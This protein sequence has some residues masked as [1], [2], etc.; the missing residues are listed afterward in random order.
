MKS[1]HVHSANRGPA[2]DMY[3]DSDSDTEDED[4]R[5]LGSFPTSVT[6]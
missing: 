3:V 2:M 4:G 6:I 1:R 5:A